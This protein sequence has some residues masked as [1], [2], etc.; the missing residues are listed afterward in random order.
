M[1]MNLEKLTP[2]RR[3]DLIRELEI[4]HRVAVVEAAKISREI[5]ELQAALAAKERRI[6][7]IDDGIEILR[8]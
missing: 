2:R 6:R 8:G 4:E 1:I 7:E 5:R 3:E